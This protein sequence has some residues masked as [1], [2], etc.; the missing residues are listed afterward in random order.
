MK[1][2]IAVVTAALATVGAATAAAHQAAP[3]TMTPGQ[4]TVAFG[5]PA[6]GFAAGT[7][8]GNTVSNPRGYEV[9]LARDIAKQLGISKINWV[10]TPWVGLFKP[11]HKSFDISFQEATITAQRAKTVTF[12]SP[13]LDSNQ[14]VLLSKTAPVPHSLADLKKLQTCAQ[15]DTTGL[16]Y[17]QARLHPQ[18]APRIYQQTSAAFTAVHVGQCQALVLDVPIVELQRKTNPSA[19]GIVAG[20]IVTNEKYGA[21][22]PKGSALAPSVD[23]AIKTLTTNGTIAKLQKKWFSISFKAVP[24]L[25]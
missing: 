16:I 20:Q 18:K 12:S 24:V 14:G 21:V 15:T 5:D 3:P 23:K 9:D 4:L 10:F 8:H 6:V 17:I 11:G 2:T 1:K 22:M 19:Y 25:K 13:Y 7:V